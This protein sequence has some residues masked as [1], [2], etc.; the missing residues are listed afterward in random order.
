MADHAWIV[1]FSHKRVARGGKPFLAYKVASFNASI[2]DLVDAE[3]GKNDLF[4]THFLDDEHHHY[5]RHLKI[6]RRIA[7]AMADREGGGIREIHFFRN[8]ILS[9]ADE[10]ASGQFMAA[11]SRVK[12][13]LSSEFEPDDSS[14]GSETLFRNHFFLPSAHSSNREQVLTAVIRNLQAALAAARHQLEGI[15]TQS[16]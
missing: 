8:R 5:T 9:A 4:S 3:A 14:V 1:I 12:T 7:K 15:S 16:E 11:T 2:E 13:S 6:A 10:K